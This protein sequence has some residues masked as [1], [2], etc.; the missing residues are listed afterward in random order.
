MIKFNKPENLNGAELLVELNAGGVKIT[1]PP[2]IDG[3]GDFWLDVAPTDEA[4]A[5][6]IVAAHNGTTVAP[7]NSAAKSAL[8]AKLGIT[9]DEAALL[10]Q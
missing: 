3:N 5:K 8:L 7:D 10:L 1:T 2:T 6:T 4:K 9:A